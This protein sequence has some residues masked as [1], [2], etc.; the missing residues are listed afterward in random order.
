M[1]DSYCGSDTTLAVQLKVNPKPQIILAKDGD[2]N[3]NKPTVQLTASGG[4]TYSWTPSAGLRNS[5]SSNPVAFVPASTTFYVSV[6]S[7]EGCE[8][9]DSIH[10]KFT[11]TGD[12]KAFQ[13]PTAFTPN[14]DGL[15]DC[16]G[17]QKWGNVEVSRMEIYNRWG[18]LVFR[19]RGYGDCWDGSFKGKPQQT[20]AFPYIIT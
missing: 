10:V 18:Q 3:C 5:S 16:F 1:K 19:G 13:V 14:G 15:N 6:K 9:K 8:A 12:L 4:S 11:G 17:I 7:A 20:A 2:F